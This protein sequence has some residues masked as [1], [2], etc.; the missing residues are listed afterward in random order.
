MVLP[1]RVEL[2]LRVPQTRV[3]TN[4]TKVAGRWLAQKVTILPPLSY[5][6]SALP[7]SYAPLFNWCKYVTLA[8]GHRLPTQTFVST[9]VHGVVVCPTTGI[10]ALSSLQRTYL[11]PV[12]SP[13]TYEET[14]EVVSTIFQ[15][16][17]T[18]FDL[19]YPLK[20]LMS[21]SFLL[22]IDN[23]ELRIILPISNQPL[24]HIN[25]ITTNNLKLIHD[26]LH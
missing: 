20:V 9:K 4:Y 15:Q 5:Q 2:E 10:P 3:L 17:Q 23:L 11:P 22:D 18:A 7:L 13:C 24:T 6:D 1:S 26:L 19:H 25:T 21:T 16:F 14:T 8:K 12:C